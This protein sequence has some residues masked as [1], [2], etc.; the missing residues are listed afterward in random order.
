[1]EVGTFLKINK[2][3]ASWPVGSLRVSASVQSHSAWTLGQPGAAAGAHA[4]WEAVPLPD[5]KAPFTCHRWPL[6]EATSRG[7]FLPKS[8]S[9]KKEKALL[10]AQAG[11]TS[12]ML[13]PSVAD[14]H[15][16]QF[17]NDSR[18][19]R[20]KKINQ[21]KICHYL[22]NVSASEA[23]DYVT[24]GHHADIPILKSTFFLF[25]RN[26]IGCTAK[27]LLHKN[28]FK[29]KC[30]NE[31]FAIRFCDFTYSFGVHSLEPLKSWVGAKEVIVNC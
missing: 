26:G 7:S 21:L 13:L 25:Q 22:A 4:S 18:C 20:K 23:R 9:Y 30:L 17:S 1:M 5:A 27:S 19:L 16:G 11:L 3:V 12:S 2:G 8:L 10:T 24:L 14:I 31:E 6:P 28:I 29:L 15:T